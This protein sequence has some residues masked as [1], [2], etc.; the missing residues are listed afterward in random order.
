MLD[1]VGER[2]VG[3]SE[4]RGGRKKKKGK[5]GGKKDESTTEL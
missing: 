1:Q 4:E 3:L 5:I 2:E